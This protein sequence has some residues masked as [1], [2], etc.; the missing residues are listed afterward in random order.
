[1]NVGEEEDRE[2]EYLKRP[3]TVENKLRA[4][5][6]EVGDGVG[7]MGNGCYCD[8]HW[9]LHVSDESQNFTPKTNITLHVN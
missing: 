7:Q 3:F 6:R 4:P 1:M 8:K 2:A 9:V 5:A